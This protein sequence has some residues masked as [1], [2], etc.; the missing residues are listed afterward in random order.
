MLTMTY[1]RRK[2]GRARTTSLDMSPRAAEQFCKAFA[3]SAHRV[4]LTDYDDDGLPV[5]VARWNNGRTSRDLP[6][7]RAPRP[8]VI[9]GEVA[10]QHD[11]TEVGAMDEIGIAVSL[12]EQ[13]SDGGESLYEGYC[14]KCQERREFSGE[15]SIS[16]NGR[17]M[18][19]GNCPVCGTKMNRIL[20]NLPH[21]EQETF[22]TP[23]DEP[24]EI[25]DEVSNKGYYG[26]PPEEEN[27]D[28]NPDAGLHGLVRS[29]SRRGTRY[30]CECG[31]WESEWVK[32]GTGAE[33]R[34]L[35]DYSAHVAESEDTETA[36]GE[37]DEDA[38]AAAAAEMHDRVIEAVAE[39]VPE[40]TEEILNA[41]SV[42]AFSDAPAKK[43]T[44]KPAKK[45]PAKRQPR[46]QAD[47]GLNVEGKP[48]RFAECPHCLNNVEVKSVPSAKIAYLVVHADTTHNHPECKGS[49]A[50]VEP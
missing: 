36:N 19:K 20:A 5:L 49:R 32:S 1:V 46:K 2:G 24:A 34:A 17:R 16:S 38:G 8:R 35:A 40:E 4:V 47:D 14:V 26:A 42:P 41:V 22:D 25:A 45:A 50:S 29:D 33:A 48:K 43:A 28:D 7:V 12:D 39:V 27:P 15:I 6:T 10:V 21:D 18:A 30:S 37:S 44:A 9:D 11:D 23:E 31:D 3:N 13:T